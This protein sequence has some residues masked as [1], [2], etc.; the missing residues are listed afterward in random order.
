L[1]LNDVGTEPSQHFDRA[2]LMLQGANGGLGIALGRSL[3]IKDDIR[4]W[5]LKPIGQPVR[6]PSNYWLVTTA[7]MAGSDGIGLLRDWLEEQIGL[8]LR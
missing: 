2:D 3:L 1:G 8:T 7:E 4:H 6:V 5:L